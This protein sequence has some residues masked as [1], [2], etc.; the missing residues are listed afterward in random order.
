MVVSGIDAATGPSVL[1]TGVG[2]ELGMA[3]LKALRQSA[4]GPRIIGTDARPI[5]V[6]LFC[7]DVAYDLP[8]ITVDEGA[9]VQR[10]K[11]ICSAE[12]VRMVCFGSE[13]ELERVAPYAEEIEADTGAKPIVMSPETLDRLWDKWK[14]VLHLRSLGLPYP[15]TALAEDDEATRELIDRHSFPL[16]LKPRRGMGAKDFFIVHHPSE[17]EYLQQRVTNAIVQ[18]YLRPDDEEYTVGTYTSVRHGYVGE[19]I[20]RRVLDSGSTYKAQVV[21]DA[22]IASVCRRAVAGDDV[23]GPV[24]LQLRKTDTGVHIFEINP[25]FSGSVPMRAHFGFNELEMA[26]VDVALDGELPRPKPRQGYALRYF[27]ELYLEPGEY[28]EDPS[29]PFEYPRPGIRIGRSDGGT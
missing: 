13:V 2:G 26:L 16:V 11:E 3:I 17:L 27:E 15:D 22:E 24:N 20:F 29:E 18:E 8:N 14:L 19:I 6:G 4:L 25:R 10:L 5:S 21:D 1:V 12:D 28:P 7:A 9:Y 23:W